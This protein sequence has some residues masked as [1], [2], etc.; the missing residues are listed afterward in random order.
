MRTWTNKLKNHSL[1]RFLAVGVLNTALSAVLMFVL[2]DAVHLGYWPSTALSYLAGAIVSFLL[3]RRFTFQSDTAVLPAALRFA[4]TVFACY[5]L[6]YSAA[7]PLILWIGSGFL[8]PDWA[9]RAAMLCGMV[10]YTAL[11]YIGQ[12]FFAFAKREQ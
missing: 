12:R 9:E 1:P 2:Y 7:K 11:N 4:I 3:N 10:L 6:A 5:L 8:T